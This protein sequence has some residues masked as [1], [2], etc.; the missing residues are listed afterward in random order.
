[1][2][3]LPA[4]CP[5]AVRRP[6]RQ[7]LRAARTWWPGRRPGAAGSAAR[8]AV[9]AAAL[10]AG[11]AAAGLRGP[12]GCDWESH[13][14]WPSGT[15][16][17]LPLALVGTAGLAPTEGEAVAAEGWLSGYLFDSGYIWALLGFVLA[18]AIICRGRRHSQEAWARPPAARPQSALP[19]VGKNPAAPVVAAPSGYGL[20]PV[21]AA[22]PA[23]NLAFDMMDRNHDG[24]I[25]RQEFQQA[26]GGMDVV[27]AS[28]PPI[29]HF[30][31]HAVKDVYGTTSGCNKAV[32]NGAL[33]VQTESLPGL[34]ARLGVM[35]ARKVIE[36][37]RMLVQE[38]EDTLVVRM[39]YLASLFH[40]WRGEATVLRVGRRFEEEFSKQKSDWEQYVT[41]QRHGCEAKLLSTETNQ[42]EGSA[43]WRQLLTVALDR[44]A[45]GDS[46]GLLLASATAWR[47]FTRQRSE[48]RAQRQRVH[49]VV[50]VWAEG[51][52]RG[53]THHC[54][55]NWRR[56]VV[57]A[58]EVRQKHR[59]LEATKQAW[60]EL[61]GEEC[62]KHEATF[63]EAQQTIIHSRAR[64]RKD[65]ALIVDMWERGDSL[66][67]QLSSIRAWREYAAS[68]QRVRRHKKSVT[69]ALLQFCEGHAS[70]ALLLCFAAWRSWAAHA[71]QLGR[72]RRSWEEL[73]SGEK[74][75][76]E[77]DLR[78]LELAE[79]RHRQRAQNAV[80]LALRQWQSGQVLGLTSEVV[81]A[82]HSYVAIRRT[83]ARRSE[84]V[85]ASL[86][87]WVEGTAM[88]GLHS[89]LI[90]WKAQTSHG[91]LARLHEQEQRKR[92][93][94]WE[95][96][97][98]DERRRHTEL[99]E[100]LRSEKEKLQDQAQAVVEYALARWEFGDDAGLL[101]RIL[102]G[103][104]L[105][106]KAAR[107]L[108]AKRQAVHLA[109]LQALKG[110]DQAITQCSF[111]N[112]RMWVRRAS[113]ARLGEARLA[114]ERARW[115][116]YLEDQRKAQK[117]GMDRA[118]SEADLRRG[119][120]H[121]ATQLMLRQW[122]QGDSA[123]LLSAVLAAWR[124]LKDD[125]AALAWRRQAAHT[126]VLR[127]CGGDDRAALQ[128]CLLNW[129]HFHKMEVLHRKEVL[130]RDREISTLEA[131]TRSMLSR[132]QSR[133]LKYS[134]ML[135]GSEDL[136]LLGAVV[137]GW[138]LHAGGIRAAETRRKLE[139]ALDE[140]RKLHDL[141]S[142]RRRHM[143]AAALQ[144][145]NTQDKQAITLDCYLNWSYHLQRQ[146][147][148]RTHQMRKSKVVAKYAWYV[149]CYFLRSDN[150]AVLAACFWELLREA[151]AQRHARERAEQHR[152]LEEFSVLILRVQDERN[153][154]EEQ[155]NQA[156]KQIDHLT[157]TM[158][159]EL[160][161]KEELATDLRE[162][163]DRLRHSSHRTKDV[164]EA[165]LAAAYP[166][167]FSKSS[168]SSSPSARSDILPHLPHA[169]L[170]TDTGGVGLL[171]S[172]QEEDAEA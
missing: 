112:W 59:E 68:A 86:F 62:S 106:A 103:W 74:E 122:Q 41:D 152:Q 56:Y 92:E 47:D 79:G 88:G 46:Q 90:H 159:K 2:G 1:M 64:A 23:A 4:P 144:A 104:A 11:A 172:A 129:K 12:R 24:V 137:W 119:R 160:K 107:Q 102:R 154:L 34:A 97:L 139:V 131:R 31:M 146:K 61:L 20:V 165:T 57:H 16:V 40:T 148:Q 37:E 171:G 15:A 81:T 22:L 50:L 140:C 132:E 170:R 134:R 85:H 43:R 95:E 151:R 55:Q 52:A 76:R 93:A 166:G 114:E 142:T 117:Q 9:S 99:E 123:G 33:A 66:G 141:A 125:A 75:R 153:G 51:D 77:D 28:V 30:S 145:L 100:D 73:L 118:Q 21:N 42:T 94:S 98:T 143:T 161:T 113:L 7:W 138:R 78:A 150:S 27:G 115:E 6:G 158:Q 130:E 82:W 54:C 72:E 149:Q 168:M 3:G 71:S 18:I 69:A 17:V 8:R 87:T 96:L 60:N 45:L 89:C 91:R 111:L 10:L 39:G 32:S 126:A 36:I 147:Q 120:A 162:A 48:L 157:E 110:D 109:L 116:T 65:V 124:Q 127:F 155:L 121:E 164:T 13:R 53:L 29:Q 35:T 49:S 14:A 25:T 58:Q 108:S 44:W 105:W 83:K 67:L 26:L 19:A 169:L 128:M 84:T 70:G 80:E 136:V 38:L 101:Q 167:G 135:G 163:Y 156:Y 5:S 133:L 63:E